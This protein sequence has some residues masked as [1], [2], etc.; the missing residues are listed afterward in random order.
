MRAGVSFQIEGVVES[1]PAEGAQ[2]ALDVRMTLH[3][4]VE[5]PLKSETL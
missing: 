2:I 5:E 4:S 3:V 1:L